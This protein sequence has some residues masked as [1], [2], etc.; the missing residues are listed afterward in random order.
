MMEVYVISRFSGK[1]RF[2][3][4]FYGAP[5]DYEGVFYPTVE[6]AFQASKT[7]DKGLRIVVRDSWSPGAA[8]KF[9]R[10]LELRPGW[11]KIKL[12]IMADLVWLKFSGDRRLA[13]K[14][15]RTKDAELVEGN[16]WGDY[17]WGVCNGKGENH[18]GK[19]LMRVR[20][21]LRKE[22]R[23]RSNVGDL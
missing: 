15:L 18:L 21:R 23:K 9:G 19:I 6:H 10:V 16:T 8:K 3:S 17:F 2:L 1:Y 12:G 13:V 5:V 11:E 7:L 22:E 14:L 20:D 4:N